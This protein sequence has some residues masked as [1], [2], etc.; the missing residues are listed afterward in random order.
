MKKSFIAAAAA[1][2]LMIAGCS[3]GPMDEFYNGGMVGAPD[4]SAPEMDMEQ[5]NPGGDNY[6]DYQDNPFGRLIVAPP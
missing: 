2:C 3:M 5:D 1:M 6:G 4:A